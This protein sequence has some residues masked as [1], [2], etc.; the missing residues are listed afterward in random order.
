MKWLALLNDHNTRKLYLL[1][2]VLSLFYTCLS[3]Y[4]YLAKDI[5]TPGVLPLVAGL[6]TWGFIIGDTTRFGNFFRKEQFAY[7]L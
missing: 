1:S 2:T 4:F 3:I 7:C 5:H 6:L